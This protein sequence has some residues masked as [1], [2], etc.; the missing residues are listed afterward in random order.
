LLPG[1]IL[2]S[3]LGAQIA[4]IITAPSALELALFALCIIAW[5]G[6]SFGIQLAIRRFSGQ[7]P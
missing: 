6:L 2:M 4:R 7:T 1:L 5:I 3:A